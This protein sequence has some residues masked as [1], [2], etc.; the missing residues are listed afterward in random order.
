MVNLCDQGTDGISHEIHVADME[1]GE[2]TNFREFE[3]VL[4]A[5]CLPGGK[6]KFFYEGN[7]KIIRQ[8]RIVRSTVRGVRD[9]FRYRC[10]DCL[11]QGTDV[12]SQT[13]RGSSIVMTCPVCEK[14]TK[15]EKTE[16]DDVK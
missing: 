16:I 13:D 6:V 11:I 12:I 9:S 3:N 5:M 10:S 14:E 4:D 2:L 15:H 7:Q 1:D 8:G